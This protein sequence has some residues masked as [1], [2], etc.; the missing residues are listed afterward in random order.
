[1]KRLFALLC[2]TFVFWAASAQRVQAFTAILYQPQTK[3]VAIHQSVWQSAFRAVKQSGMDVVVFQW[4]GYGEAFDG[5][6]SQ[7]WLKA[8]MMD[9]IDADL[10]L[11][12]GLYADP[13][14][15]SAVDV[16]SDLLEPYFLRL[17]E[18]NRALASHWE[19]QLPSASLLAWYLPLELDDRRWRAPD[20][21][22]ALVSGL[23][24]DVM[25]LNPH[26]MRPVYVST[27]FR[28][29]ATP[30]AYEQMLTTVRDGA[31]VELWVQDGRGSHVLHEQ[32][33]VLYLAPFNRC[34]T[35]P[36]KGVVFEIFK[37]TGSDQAFE[38]K[39][40]AAERKR[41]AIKQRSPCGGD[42]VFFSLRYFYPIAPH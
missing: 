36:I 24:R 5:P 16:S 37:E 29:H 3:D 18:K 39:P 10:K 27:F 25:A 32:E 9:A 13:D 41:A 2:L 34:E 40:L 12:V 20:D 33:T 21:L 11:V 42:S 19:K 17:T 38:A 8:R 28:G 30:A 23:R 14:M 22:T 35:S 7:A 6:D 1:M 4:T 31:G 15:F 26:G